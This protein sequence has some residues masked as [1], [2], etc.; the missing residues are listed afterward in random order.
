TQEQYVMKTVWD[1][2][3]GTR[4]WFIKDLL[5]KKY[6]KKMMPQTISTFLKKLVEKGYIEAYRDGR[7]IC[8][9]ILIDIEEY[10]K[11]LLSNS[12]KFWYDGDV[13]KFQ[14]DF[15]LISGK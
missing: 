13:S 4:L 12:L 10:R 9:K 7:Y 8:Y 14:E 15:D 6:K 1:M 3:N 11:Y 5:E 2:G